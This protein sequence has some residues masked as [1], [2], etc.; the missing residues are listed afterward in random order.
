MRKAGQTVSKIAVL[1]LGCWSLTM[2]QACTAS[3]AISAKIDFVTR[4]HKS[5]LDISLT[6]SVSLRKTEPSDSSP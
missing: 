2:S 3:R 4:V 6:A 5:E 1:M